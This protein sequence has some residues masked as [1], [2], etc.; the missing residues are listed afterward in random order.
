MRITHLSTPDRAPRKKEKMHIIKGR[1]EI[2]NINA[3]PPKIR[4][5]R[6]K[7]ERL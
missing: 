2:R 1:N 7:Y 6:G 3:N 4:N 5:R